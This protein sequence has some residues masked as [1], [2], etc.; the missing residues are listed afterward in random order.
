MEDNSS[1]SDDATLGTKEVE[2]AP[3]NE[4]TT[5]TSP[6]P[7]RNSAAA[8]HGI[9]SNHSPPTGAAPA[10]K[11]P[12]R[13][14]RLLAS[15][16]SLETNISTTEAQLSRALHQISQSDAFKSKQEDTNTNSD[17][18]ALQHAQHTVAN[19]INLLKSYNEIKDIAMG[20]L[21]L[22]ADKEGRRVA[23]VMEQRGIS[24]RD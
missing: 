5:S 16:A 3:Q 22:I 14:T 7:G 13:E 12:S 18:A 2:S 9:D 11:T 19:H 24:E 15:I 23:E 21:G 4:T 20:M 10:S 8:S 17:A 1:R 6:K